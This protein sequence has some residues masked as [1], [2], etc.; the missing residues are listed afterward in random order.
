MGHPRQGEHDALLSCGDH[1][2]TR[3][4]TTGQDVAAAVREF[5]AGKVEYRA[6][7]GGNVHA[8]VG[9]MSFDDDKLVANI[10][11]FVEQIRLVKP[12]GVKGHYVK[13]I[14]LSST[15]GPGVKIALAAVGAGG[16]A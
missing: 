8:G 14:S 5:K 15:M 9:K 1:V 10:T 4:Y 3:R 7:K 12:S 2:H 6:D 11:T 13:K 16:A